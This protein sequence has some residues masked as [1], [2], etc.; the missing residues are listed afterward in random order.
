MTL[1]LHCFS[2]PCLRLTVVNRNAYPGI[3]LRSGEKKA[4]KTERN[5]TK[6]GCEASRV[7]DLRGE[8]VCGAPQPSPILRIR[9]GSRRP[10]IYMLHIMWRDIM[11]CLVT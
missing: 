10:L 7:V 2:R 4:K 6:W 8:K 1:S 11:L 3:T 5:S 9:I